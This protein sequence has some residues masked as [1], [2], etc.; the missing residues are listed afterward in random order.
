MPFLRSMTFGI[1]E[2][3]LFD[4]DA[5]VGGMVGEAPEFGGVEQRFGRNAADMEAG[6]AQLRIFFDNRGFQ[7]V[8]AGAH[9]GRV[10]AG[11][12]TNHNQIVCHV[13]PFYMA[14]HL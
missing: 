1:I 12:A 3:R 10:A 6:A 13:T 2:R 4:G 8:L 9:R 5:F 14:R 7:A 11:A